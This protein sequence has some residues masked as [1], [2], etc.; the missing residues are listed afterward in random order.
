MRVVIQRVSQASVTIAATL[1]S[2]IM[3]GL[4]VLVG[5]EDVDTIDDIDFLCKKIVN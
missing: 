5:I 4:L 1:K 2:Q 3:Q